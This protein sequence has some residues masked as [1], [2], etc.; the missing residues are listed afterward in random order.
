MSLIPV[1]IM[2]RVWRWVWIFIIPASR[3]VLAHW[4]WFTYTV[5]LRG[6]SLPFRRPT[7]TQQTSCRPKVYEIRAVPCGWPWTVSLSTAAVRLKKRHTRRVVEAYL[8]GSPQGRP[9]PAAAVLLMP[10]CS[11]VFVGVNRSFMRVLRKRQN[12]TFQLKVTWGGERWFM[13]GIRKK[14]TARWPLPWTDYSSPLKEI[15]HQF[16]DLDC[17]THTG[18]LLPIHY[19]AIRMQR[20]LQIKSR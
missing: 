8:F 7:C 3:F 20:W 4:H 19:R 18:R 1:L 16:K 11:R 12:L 2:F 14:I 10:P 15:K 5:R 6:V 17:W 9:L 13:F